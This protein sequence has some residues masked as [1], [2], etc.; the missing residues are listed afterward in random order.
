[1][2]VRRSRL[3]LT[4]P[5]RRPRPAGQSPTHFSALLTTL[6]EAIA[7]ILSQHQ[8]VVEKYY[9]EGKMVSV[10]GSLMSETDRLGLKVVANWEEERRVR[11]RVNEVKQHRF[12]GVGVLRKAAAA[13]AAQAQGNGGAGQPLNRSTSPL[14]GQPGFDGSASVGSLSVGGAQGGNQA[15]EGEISPRETD[16]VLGELTMMSGRWQL[17]RRFLY[18]SLLVR[19]LDEALDA[20]DRVGAY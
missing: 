7:L 19:R 5:Y 10:A 20:A 13:A 16:A 2:T 18:G 14:A 1:M 9:G 8:P 3:F 4:Y 17:L 6:F 11:R 12:A 15:G